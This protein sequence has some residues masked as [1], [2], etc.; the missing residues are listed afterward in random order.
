MYWKCC[1]ERRIPPAN[2][3]SNQTRIPTI[4]CSEAPIAPRLECLVFS[5]RC[6]ICTA[7]LGN[8]FSFF[9]CWLVKRQVIWNEQ[10]TVSTVRWG[11]GPRCLGNTTVIILGSISHPT[12]ILPKDSIS[13]CF[14]W[15][16][17]HGFLQL[18]DRCLEMVLNVISYQSLC[19]I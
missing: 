5:S 10:L 17:F 18:I 3:I 9:F 7:W 13:S 12:L 6:I 16:K 1:C 14:L 8:I 2:I 19:E 4:L 15:I 11:G